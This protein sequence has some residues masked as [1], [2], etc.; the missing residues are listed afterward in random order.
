MRNHEKMNRQL[1]QGIRVAEGFCVS[2]DKI[3]S[4]Y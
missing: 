1:R 2:P 3:K 4:R